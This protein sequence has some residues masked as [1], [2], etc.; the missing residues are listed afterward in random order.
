MISIHAPLAGRDK[1]FLL[2]PVGSRHF[3]PRAPCGA[4]QQKCTNIIVQICK[5]NNSK[6]IILKIRVS[7][8]VFLL[9]FD[10]QIQKS[11]TI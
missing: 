5:K 10:Q 2:L 6:K 7:K 11:H 3:N 1:Q 8:F 4:R 9:M